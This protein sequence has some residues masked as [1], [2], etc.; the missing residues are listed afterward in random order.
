M[1]EK[2]QW[3]KSRYLNFYWITSAVLIDSSSIELN[4]KDI[5]L[6]ITIDRHLKFDNKSIISVKKACQKLN[7]F[8]HFATFMNFAKKN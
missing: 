4:T 3:Q 7:A 6:G 8:L 1:Y 2:E 5:L